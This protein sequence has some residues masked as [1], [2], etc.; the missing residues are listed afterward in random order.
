MRKHLA[1]LIAAVILPVLAFAVPAQARTQYPYR[2]IDLGTFG[3]PSSFLDMP[4]V[5][6]TGNGTVLGR[7]SR[8]S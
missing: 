7:M 1:V 5:P 4:G 6:I 8:S 2:L 3:G